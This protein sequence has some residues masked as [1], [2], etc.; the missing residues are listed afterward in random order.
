MTRFVER[1]AGALQLAFVVGIVG[2]ALLFSISLRPDSPAP[3]PSAPNSEQTV[4]IVTPIAAPY[5]PAVRL[6]GVVEARTVTS[7]IP[8][9]AG[10]VVKV[11]PAFR[12]GASVLRGDL[13]FQIDA[14]DYRLAVERTLAEIEVARSDLARLEAEAAAER[15]IWEKQF[16]NRQIPDLIARVPQIAAAK[17]R[18]KSGEAARQAAELS[19]ARTTVRAPFDARILDTQ[20]DVGQVVSGNAAVGTMFSVESVEI[21]VPVSAEERKLIGPL[22]GQTV[23]VIPPDA[24]DAPIPGRVLRVAAALDERTR[25]G[26]LFVAT[27]NPAALTV[28][29]FVEVQINGADAPDAYRVPAGALT[30]R[31]RLWVVADGRLAARTVDVVGREGDLAVV[32]VFDEADGVVIV[33][34]ANARDGL[35]VIGRLNSGVAAAKTRTD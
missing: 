2:L 5:Q 21:A 7:I 24:T 14:S 13:L 11:S 22:N 17:A 25:L 9:V 6:N 8:Q 28:G 23:T 29:E 31:D 15:D 32:K 10:R 12:Q 4:S 33:P 30:S 1:H 16:P 20:L 34:P 18:I 3:R 35:P 19:L 26:T 27:D